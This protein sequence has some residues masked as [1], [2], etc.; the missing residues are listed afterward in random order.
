MRRLQIQVSRHVSRICPGIDHAVNMED[1]RHISAA[2]L[3]VFA[4]VTTG[5]ED[6][7]LEASMT[8]CELIRYHGYPCEA[9]YATTDDGYMLQVVRVAHGVRSDGRSAAGF[10]FADSGFDVWAMSNRESRP[11]TN[12]TRFSQRDPKHWQWSFDELGR[13]DL[14]ACIDH[15]LKATGSPKL[16][17]VA[18]SQGVMANLVLHSVRPEYNNKKIVYP[19]TD[20]GYLG[21]TKA[22]RAL[23]STACHLFG[24]ALCAL[25][26]TLNDFCSPEQFNKLWEAKTSVFFFFV[27]Y[28]VIGFPSD[29]AQKAAWTKAVRRENFAP[30]KYSVRTAPP[31]PLERIRL[32]VALFW[33]HGD[34]LAG[35][36]DVST[37]AAALGSNVIMNY[38]VPVPT[39]RH[40]D[41]ATGYRAN[42]IV[43][44][45][46]LELIRSRIDP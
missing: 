23:I 41:F 43:H 9:S 13:Y 5:K 3:L 8:P 31:Y 15:V 24:G 30:T 7:K 32:P 1:L 17:T 18:L 19:F 4:A 10:L 34:T 46:A 35:A 20:A 22:L 36:S 44:N 38:V 33:S 6:M 29:S 26:F 12:S 28:Y 27:R 25:G 16:T 21:T 11:Y 2:W 37:M 14:A 45:V 39:F 42:D 40:L